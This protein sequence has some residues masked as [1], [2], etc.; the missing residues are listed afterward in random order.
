MDIGRLLGC[1]ETIYN[2]IIVEN[3]DNRVIVFNSEVNNMVLEDIILHILKW[4]KEDKDLPVDKR[5][6]IKLYLNSGGGDVF[7]GFNLIDVI[8]SSNT[9]VYGICFSQCASMAFHIF[10]ACHKRYCFKNSILLMH[11][12]IVGVQNSSSKAKDTMKFFDSIEARTKQHVLKY[13]SITEEFYDENYNRELYFYGD[14]EGRELNCVD[15]VVDE[16]C[17]LSDIL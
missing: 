15:F 5:Q 12:G 4:N 17:K 11:D 10:I 1:N 14:K 9:P 8:A 13:T 16:D 7:S 6:P 3:L 2:D